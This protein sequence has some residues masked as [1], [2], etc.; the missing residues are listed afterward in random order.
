M[1]LGH[2]DLLR[3][4]AGIEST[5]LEKV[6]RL[7]AKHSLS[8]LRLRALKQLAELKVATIGSV[9]TELKETTSGGTF[10]SNRD[11]FNALKKEGI[12]SSKKVGKTTYWEISDA[13]KELEKY[14]LS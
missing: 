6:F 9:L 7:M 11:F 2:D 14:L 8:E 13:A 5:K 1:I 12:L 10:I 4:M 3:R